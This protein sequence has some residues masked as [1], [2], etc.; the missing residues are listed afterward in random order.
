[1]KGILKRHNLTLYLIVIIGIVFRVLNFEKGFAFAH[2]QDLYSW[3][4]K[5]IVLNHHQRLVGQITSVAGVFIGSFY[6]YLMAFFYWLA[7]MNP[8]SAVFPLTMIGIVGI[9]SIYWIVNRHFG[10]KAAYISCFIQ[11]CSIGIALF[12]RWSVPTQPTLLWSI[13]FVATII[14]LYKGNL[15]FL[16]LY[17]FLIGFVWQLHI[18]LIPILPIPI[19]AFLLNKSR[20]SSLLQRANARLIILSMLILFVV[21]S[22]FFLFE[23]KYNFSQIRSI[24]I[25]NEVSLGGPTG[26]MKMVKVLD[27]SSREIQQRIMYGWEL[28]NVVV[29]WAVGIVFMLVLW[30]RKWVERPLLLLLFSWLA[31]ILLAQFWSKRIVSEYYFTNILPIM[32]ILT[33]VFLSRVFNQKTLGLLGFGYLSVNL[34]WL[35]TKTD[36]DHSYFYRKQ[37]VDYIGEDIKK[38]SYPCVAINFIADPG[39]GVGFRYLFWYRGVSLVKP[40]TPGA[41]I[42][43]IPIPWQISADED[44]VHFGRFGVL[45]PKAVAT[46]ISKEDCAKPEYQLDPLLGYTE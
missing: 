16:P 30:I 21:I 8:L 34:F 1:M 13:W 2:D 10:K 41:V 7:N 37:V 38:N 26:W 6:Y 15:K 35:I 11:S 9:F 5:D 12:D 43:N 20:A 44:P 14:E 28:K 3:I 22:P 40:G 18:A 4:A 33:S 39:V 46:M 17:A 45:L 32:V 24:L 27:A 31:L 36:V 42:Y 29:L 23:L 19:I 25:A